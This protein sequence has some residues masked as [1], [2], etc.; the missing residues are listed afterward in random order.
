MA[1][2]TTNTRNFDFG[3]I[4]GQIADRAVAGLSEWHYYLMRPLAAQPVL[5]AAHC[6]CSSLGHWRS[7]MGKSIAGSVAHVLSPRGLA[8]R[9][10]RQCRLFRPTS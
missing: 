7:G 2:F 3:N 10:L 6:A 8:E 9:G 4:T 5:V 1:V